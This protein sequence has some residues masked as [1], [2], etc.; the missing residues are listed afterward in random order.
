[1]AIDSSVVVIASMLVSPI[2]GPVLAFTFGATM[3]NK[4]LRQMGLRN[5][6]ISLLICV[7]VG[8]IIGWFWPWATQ[9]RQDWPTNE[10]TSRGESWYILLDGAYIAAA[11]GVG[12]ALSVVGDYTTTTVCHQM[13]V[14]NIIQLISPLLLCH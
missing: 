9:N 10:M 1:M 4:D 11:S 8:V 12:V 14:Y 5:E 6:A 13:Y 3:R 2:M 7:V